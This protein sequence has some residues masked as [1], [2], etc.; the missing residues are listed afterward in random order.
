M[1]I[2]QD[3][4]CCFDCTRISLIILNAIFCIIGVSSLVVG[5]SMV[6]KTEWFISFVHIEGLEY[7]DSSVSTRNLNIAGYT[8]IAFG[9]VLFIFMLLGLFGSSYSNQCLLGSYVTCIIVI[10]IVKVAM[11]VFIYL[12]WKNY[13]REVGSKLKKWMIQEHELYK[14]KVGQIQRNHSCCGVT[15]PADYLGAHSRLNTCPRNEQANSTVD[16]GCQDAIVKSFEEKLIIAGGIALGVALMEILC[17][18]LAN[19]LVCSLRSDVYHYD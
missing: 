5:L 17:I 8:L 12:E 11:S 10:L 4:D 9:G 15:G 13:E 18:V 6:L 14:E 1:G 3:D 19:I 16:R 7:I 2:F